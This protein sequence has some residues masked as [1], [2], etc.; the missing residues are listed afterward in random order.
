MG[1]KPALKKTEEKIDGEGGRRLVG[2]GG[3]GR[4]SQ[5]AYLRDLSCMVT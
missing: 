1:C 4:G 5:K 3:E 2:R